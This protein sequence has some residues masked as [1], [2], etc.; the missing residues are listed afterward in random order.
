MNR[1]RIISAMLNR[2]I[3]KGKI[4]GL[5]LEIPTGSQ[6]ANAAKSLG[7]VKGIMGA[8]LEFHDLDHI[9]KTPQQIKLDVCDDLDASK[10]EIEKAVKKYWPDYEKVKGTK[11]I[12]EAQYDALA[13]GISCLENNKSQLEEMIKREYTN[14]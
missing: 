9:Y 1:A 8:L 4:T 6:N 7:M 11:P 12:R 3:L 13:V 5:C 2:V 14:E 10:A